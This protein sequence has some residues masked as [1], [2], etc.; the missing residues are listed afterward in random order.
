MATALRYIPFFGCMIG[1]KYPQ[2]EAAVRKTVPALGIE[3][4]DV[5]GFTCCPDPIYFKASD[6]MAWLSIAA[7]NLTLAEEAGLP[8]VTMCSGCT[9]TLSEVNHLLTHDSQLR[10]RVNERLRRIGREFK[11]TTSVRHIVTVVRDQVGIDRVAASVVRPLSGVRV[12]IHYGC[13]LL[14]PSK[15]M[16][17]D[18]PD[19]PQI[20]ESLVRATGAEP[21]DHEER[22]LCCGKA[23]EDEEIPAQMTR[24]VLTSVKRLGVD[25]MGLICPT[26]F[27]EYDLGQFKLARKFGTP[28][29]LPVI[30]YF[31]LLG[32]AQGY[33]PQE[34]GL[35]RHKVKVEP[36]LAKIGAQ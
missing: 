15:I 36:L 9:A 24:D 22:L 5:Q 7:R 35:H 2:F 30:Y 18:D 11:G 32:L 17:V 28:F 12:A 21:V 6:K 13:H 4:V 10:D 33:G 14:K 23:C 8:I 1:V 34:M 27:D 25:C 20:L 19:R 29:E 26:C 3:L 16:Q 31:Q